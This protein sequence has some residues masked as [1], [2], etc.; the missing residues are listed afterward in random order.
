MGVILGNATN[1]KMKKPRLTKCG[2]FVF[3]F[4]GPLG[5]VFLGPWRPCWSHLRECHKPKTEKTTFNKVWFFRFWAFK[6]LCVLFFRGPG[7][8]VEPS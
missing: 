5:F 1:P 4:A 3:C 7:G 2:F 8:H 6:G